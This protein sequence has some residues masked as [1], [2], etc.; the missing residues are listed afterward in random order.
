MSSTIKRPLANRK[1]ITGNENNRNFMLIHNLDQKY[2]SDN[3]GLK[4]RVPSVSSFMLIYIL[5]V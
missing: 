5:I 4:L 3:Q 1:Q 2:L